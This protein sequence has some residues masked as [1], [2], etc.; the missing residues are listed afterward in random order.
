MKFSSKW[1]VT[2]VLHPLDYLFHFLTERTHHN[3][4]SDICNTNTPLL[5]MPMLLSFSTCMRVRKTFR[6]KNITFFKI[7]KILPSKYSAAKTIK[8]VV[9]NVFLKI[10]IIVSMPLQT[11]A[12][13]I[14]QHF[15]IHISI[16]V[17][18]SPIKLN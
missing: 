12:K 1:I 9:H 18:W 15:T 5:K 11:C 6:K 8:Y 7:K 2:H 17:S 13:I 10:E 4:K 14:H 16:T 3:Y